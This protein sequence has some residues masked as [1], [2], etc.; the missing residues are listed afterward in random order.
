MVIKREGDYIQ[1]Q[2]VS[3]NIR[4][5]GYKYSWLWAPGLKPM[6]YKQRHQQ[7]MKPGS[8]FPN[9]TVL[10]K[11]IWSKHWKKLIL[12]QNCFRETNF[13][14]TFDK[15]WFTQHVQPSRSLVSPHASHGKKSSQDFYSCKYNVKFGRQTA[16][17]KT[18]I[19]IRSLVLCE[20][21]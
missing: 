21:K 6:S 7:Q 1:P 4:Q 19:A 18:I 3:M 10:V 2:W 11:W 14:N 13:T 5:H 16:L 17:E 9:T 12:K 20:M 8:L 15:H